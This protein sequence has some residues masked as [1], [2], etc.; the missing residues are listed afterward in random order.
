[1]KLSKMSQAHIP[2][3]NANAPGEQIASTDMVAP[4]ISI[5]TPAPSFSQ[6][7]VEAVGMQNG[8]DPYFYT[9]FRR[10]STFEWSTSDQ[11]GKMLWS[12]SLSPLQMDP[13]LAYLA[14]LYLAWDGDFVFNFKIAGTGFHAGMLTVCKFPPTIDPA[15]CSDPK[16]FSIFPWNGTD[17]KQLEIS[18]MIG[19]DIRPI[20]YHYVQKQP[21]APPD[22]YIG[23]HVAIFVDLPLATS[24]SGVPRVNVAVWVKVTPNFR[25]IEMVPYDLQSL[26][27]TS[28]APEPL[29]WLLNFSLPLPFSLSNAPLI[30]D[31]LLVLPDTIKVLN[32]GQYNCFMLNGKPLSSYYQKF[33]SET[34]LF[35]EVKFGESDGSTVTFQHDNFFPRWSIIPDEYLGVLDNKDS[36]RSATLTDDWKILSDAPDDATVTANVSGDLTGRMVSFTALTKDPKEWRD[37]DNE[38]SA[39]TSTESFVM[40]A[41]GKNN[42]ACVQTMGLTRLFNSGKLST[43]IPPGQAAVFQL[44]EVSSNLPLGLVKLYKEG[45]FTMRAVKDQVQFSLTDLKMDFQYMTPETADLVGAPTAALAFKTVAAEHRRYMKIR[46]RT[47]GN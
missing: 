28:M 2:Q 40:F 34:A 9:Q 5:E 14:Q 26:E 46:R 13:N 42:V 38:R 8:I 32:Y 24:S 10:L 1:M 35:P 29:P 30:P 37:T 27:P 19:R 36:A 4:M 16:R 11:T 12:R 21:L 39:R 23:G 20:K 33:Y 15:T 44:V 45:F 17:P 7:G 41:A 47:L 6:E 3:P 22:Y 43:W 25:F 18:S 31:K